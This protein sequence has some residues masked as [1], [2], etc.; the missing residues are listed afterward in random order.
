[1][2]EFQN[3][4]VF[5]IVGSAAGWLLWKFTRK[6]ASGCDSCNHCADE[7]KSQLPQP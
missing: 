5:L 6:K 7:P 3:I 2:F 4:I 1:M